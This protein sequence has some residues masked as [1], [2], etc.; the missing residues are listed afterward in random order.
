MVLTAGLVITGLAVAGCDS[1]AEGDSRSRASA[2]S[3]LT[4]T[5]LQ[6][7]VPEGYDPCV[8]VPQSV[9]DSENLV[10]G[11]ANNK[12]NARGPGD[13]EWRGCAWAKAGGNGYAVSIQ[14]TNVTIPFVR[15]HYSIDRREFTIAGR[16]AISVRKNET[17]PSEVCSINVEMKGGSLEFHLDNPAS[18]RETG[19]IDTCE[20]GVA[21]AE[22]VV[23]TLPPNT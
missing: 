4:S 20:L 17:R 19:H 3:T 18:N 1:S 12:A 11:I 2:T 9:L 21:L 13:T 5:G 8:D 16:P 15:E 23:S 6:T 14:V 22:K 7:T 10:K